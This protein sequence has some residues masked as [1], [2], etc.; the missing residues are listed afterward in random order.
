MIP[1]GA[2]TMVLR[3]FLF[4]GVVGRSLTN[5]V[6]CTIS[7]HEAAFVQNLILQYIR[8]IVGN[9]NARKKLSKKQTDIKNDPRQFRS[10][11][12]SASRSICLG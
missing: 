11:S 1:N 3:R 12:E 2:G 7:A 6:Y 9:A 4:S 8:D 5:L 10:V